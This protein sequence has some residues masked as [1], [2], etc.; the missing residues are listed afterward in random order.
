MGACGSRQIEVIAA[1][2]IPAMKAGSPAA[3]PA[4]GPAPGVPK[5]SP[6]VR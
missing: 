3:V 5:G 6:V 4:N 2:Q 1:G